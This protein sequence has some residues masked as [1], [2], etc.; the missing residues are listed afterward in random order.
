MFKYL[1]QAMVDGEL[2]LL[3]R[4]SNDAPGRRLVK[5]KV[6]QLLQIFIHTVQSHPHHLCNALLLLLLIVLLRFRTR[7]PSPIIIWISDLF[8]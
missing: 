1:E 4:S 6:Q 5:I 8:R 3:E 2:N 7:N